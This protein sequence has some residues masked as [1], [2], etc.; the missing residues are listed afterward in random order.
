[1]SIIPSAATASP[2]RC[3]YIYS[4][5]FSGYACPVGY[6]F[7]GS[8][9]TT[10]YQ[11]YNAQLN[12]RCTGAGET[13]NGA[14]C[15][16]SATQ[17]LCTGATYMGG[18]MC[19]DTYAATATGVCNSGYTK[20]GSY[21]NKNTAACG[22]T[23][24]GTTGGSTY[25]CFSGTLKAAKVCSGTS[26]CTGAPCGASPGGYFGI[27]NSGGVKCAGGAQDATPCPAGTSMYGTSC[28]CRDTFPQAT[29]YSCNAGDSLS[30]TTCTTDYTASWQCPLGY[31][32]LV[33]TT[34][35]KAASSYYTCPSGG[36]LSGSTCT[37]ST[38]SLPV[39][40][41]PLGGTLSGTTC[42]LPDGSCLTPTSTPTASNTP[43]PSNTPTNTPTRTG[44]PTPSVTPSRTGTPTPSVTP[45]NTG[46]PTTTN[47]QTP[48][49]SA[50]NTPS[51]TTTS[52]ATPSA[53]TTTTLTSTPTPSSTPPPNI[54]WLPFGPLYNFNLPIRIGDA[55]LTPCFES[56][57][58]G[59]QQC[60]IKKEEVDAKWFDCSTRVCLEMYALEEQIESLDI[61]IKTITLHYEENIRQQNYVDEF[62]D[63][64][65]TVC[66][67]PSNTPAPAVSPSSTQ[68]PTARPTPTQTPTPTGSP[69]PARTPTPSITPTPTR[70]YIPPS[71]SNTPSITP[72]P[73]SSPMCTEWYCE[74]PEDSLTGDSPPRCV[75]T[76]EAQAGMRR[77][78]WYCNEWQYK[79]PMSWG[80]CYDTCPYGMY[81]YQP[82]ME[83]VYSCPYGY[84]GDSYTYACIADGG[85]GGGGSGSCSNGQLYDGS[86]C[87]DW[88]SMGTF[89]D[90][91]TNMCVT[92]CPSGTFGDKY[93]GKCVDRCSEPYYGEKTARVCVEGCPEFTKPND[94]TRICE[95]SLVYSCLDPEH[96]LDGTTCHRYAGAQKR[97]CCGNEIC[98]PLKGE[99]KY[100]CPLDC[101]GPDY[102]TLSWT[103][104]WD[105]LFTIQQGYG[106]DADWTD[107]HNKFDYCLG[108]SCSVQLSDCANNWHSDANSVC[109]SYYVNQDREECGNSVHSIY[110]FTIMNSQGWNALANAQSQNNCNGGGGG[111]TC[112][113]SFCDS[114]NGEDCYSCSQD[115]GDCW[116]RRLRS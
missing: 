90:Y 75:Y 18:G 107:A 68:T 56:F 93:Y 81:T 79:D 4:A 71:K 35:S 100:T 106:R 37:L 40:T 54:D 115:C 50:S 1:M 25:G 77:L 10:C 34:C 64:Q 31:A 101:K 2:S 27:M 104:R 3:P 29:T 52:S 16:I 87:V 26:Y 42:T 102:S 39:Y 33:G 15:E 61:C 57:E 19:K 55:D 70:T 111:A 97:L 96:R 45:S 63:I 74:N 86:M 44:T 17:D 114:I 23:L 76:Y 89:A 109:D 108:S 60:G 65:M 94:E 67:S 28:Q 51:T 38:A 22:A 85:G 30:A 43:T 62:K 32:N 9:T 13:L 24:C 8:D 73:T 88:C 83:C 72:S 20:S 84:T 69:T 48:T 21:C 95:S 6:S 66:V 46:T 91:N 78:Q 7:V 92:Q 98:E 14:S 112:G 12:Y 49:P 113:D 110:S 11:S 53:S 36:S 58:H 103:S 5:S 59:Y 105:G 47:T 80:S 116:R 82:S 41:C 99:D